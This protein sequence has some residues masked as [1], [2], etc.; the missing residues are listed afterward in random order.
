MLIWMPEKMNIQAANKL[1][2]IIEE[3]PKN[4]VF[5]GCREYREYVGYCF[6]SYTIVKSARHSDQEVLNY[7]M[8]RGV[9]QAKAKMISNLVDGNI[10][11]ALQLAEHVEDSSK[12]LEFCTVDALVF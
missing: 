1:L 9:E 7:L 12:T 11:E 2:K 8:N 5:I 10:N 6:V 4:I 3:P